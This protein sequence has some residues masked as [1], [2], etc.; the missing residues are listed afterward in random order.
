[1]DFSK[2]LTEDLR[3]VSKEFHGDLKGF[4][5]KFRCASV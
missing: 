1:M 3:G 4:R 2:V 5:N